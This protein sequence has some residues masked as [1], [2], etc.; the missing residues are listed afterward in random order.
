MFSLRY[1][2][3]SQEKG[4]KKKKSK[5]EGERYAFVLVSAIKAEG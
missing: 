4:K 1:V 3:N 5:E 2:I